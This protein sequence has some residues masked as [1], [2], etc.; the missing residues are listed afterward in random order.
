MTK[1]L[2]VAPHPDD[3]TL[4]CGGTLL[5]HKAAG[6]EIHWLIASCMDPSQGYSDAQISE[7]ERIISQVSKSYA[8]D[9]VTQLQYVAGRLDTYS[10]GTLVSDFKCCLERIQ[11]DTLYLPYKY[12]VHT[13]HA[14]VFNAM[15]SA[16]KSFRAPY[17]K[18]WLAYETLSESE[19]SL[20]P[21]NVH[22]NPNV[23]VD[24]SH[25]RKA[26]L[27][28]C[29]LYHTEIFAHPFPRSV[30]AVNA[31][32]TLRGAQCN[33]DAAESFVLLKEIL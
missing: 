29:L 15:V 14:V 26:K 22:F 18:R 16:S 32:L 27:S 30:E 24:V 8:F 11:P 2:V 17:V 31:K 28:I 3:E 5:K 7:R 25:F 1:V 6:D 23:F 10:T 19:F 13:D 12:D 9:S 33:V 20:D 21:L 4:G